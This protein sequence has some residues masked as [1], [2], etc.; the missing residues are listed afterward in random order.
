MWIDDGVHGGGE[1]GGRHAGL[2]QGLRQ[3]LPRR[4]GALGLPYA[5]GPPGAFLP[6]VLQ[7]HEVPA[8]FSRANPLESS[9]DSRQDRCAPRIPISDLRPRAFEIDICGFGCPV[10]S[11][12]L[13]TRAL[14]AVIHVPAYVIF[15]AVAN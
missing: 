2:P 4:R 6:Y 15:C 13:V 7:P 12:L 8:S 9:I 5:H 11:P 1:G 14:G 3:A 10:Y